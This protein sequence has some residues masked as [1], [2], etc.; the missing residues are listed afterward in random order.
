MTVII[1]AEHRPSDSPFVERVWRGRVDGVAL[2]TSVAAS[3][4]E[5]VVSRER[6]RLQVV[7]RGPET[8][9]STVAT[10]PDSTSFGIVFAHGVAISSIPVTRLVDAEAC[11]PHVTATSFLLAGDRW[12]L[13]DF[14]TAEILVDRLVRRGL[15]IRDPLVADAIAGEASRHGLRTVQRRVVAST[16]LTLGAIRRIE[17]ARQAALLLREGT[18]P[19]DVVHRLGYYDQPHLARSLRRFIGRTAGELRT[20]VTSQSG[21][22]L[23]LLYKNAAW[24]HP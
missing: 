4:W 20:G 19:L 2:M 15:L 23:S 21:Q 16:G 6:G 12:E 3:S 18:R 7:A 8:A 11:S 17:R 22:A 13:P 9:A 10:T 14:D 1:D 5:L 24:E